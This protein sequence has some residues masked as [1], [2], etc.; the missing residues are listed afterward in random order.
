MS[1]EPTKDSGLGE[2]KKLTHLVDRNCRGPI[3]GIDGP[4]YPAFIPLVDHP[5]EKDVHDC[6][7]GGPVWLYKTSRFDVVVPIR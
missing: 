2:A 7:K 4:P 1:L 3:S 5:T 6:Q